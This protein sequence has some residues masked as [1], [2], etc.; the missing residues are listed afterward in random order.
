[1]AKKTPQMGPQKEEKKRELSKHSAEED[2]HSGAEWSSR[3][4]VKARRLL[5]DRKEYSKKKPI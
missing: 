2:Q 5:K 1:M 3:E 4:R